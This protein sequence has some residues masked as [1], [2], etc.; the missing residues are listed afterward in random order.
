MFPTTA[1]T[2]SPTL[3]PTPSPTPGP[4]HLSQSDQLLASSSEY[5]DFFGISVSA[6]GDTV[7]VGA[8]ARDARAFDS[9]AAHVFTRGESGWSEQVM[10]TPADG[11]RGDQFGY[12]VSVSGDIAVI[13]ARGDSDAVAESGSAYV[14]HKGEL[15]WGQEAKLTASD[16]EMYDNFGHSVSVS[17]DTAIIGAYQD[18][19]GGIDTGSAYVFHKDDEDEWSQQAKL[20]A[21]DGEASD[22]F[23]YSV[24]ISGDTAVVG[25]YGGEVGGLV[26]GSAYVFYRDETGWSQQA[27]L[28]ALDATARDSFGYSVSVSG[29]TVVVGAYGDEDGGSSSGSA[30]VFVRDAG[31]WSQEAKLTASDPEAFDRFGYSVSVSGDKVVVGAYTDNDGSTSSGSVYV[32]VRDAGMWTQEA[33]LTAEDYAEGD[34][35]GYS[36]S[37]SG[38]TVVGGSLL[39]QDVDDDV[40]A[41]YVFSCG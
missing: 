24:S 19:V 16:A 8:Y 36:V 32:F 4:F 2:L 23:G 39:N 7:V 22:Q 34:S 38:D 33:K 11:A 15:G 27:K 10:L 13:G 3:V 41:A 30:Y 12:S 28:I 25:A 14:F 21:S 6:S 5:L 18:V 1:P 20:T 31:M 29:D 35:F 9:G 40:G 37:V 17:G 26:V